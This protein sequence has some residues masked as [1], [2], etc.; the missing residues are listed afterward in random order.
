MKKAFKTYLEDTPIIAAVKNDAELAEAIKT[1]IQVI[2]I[3][4]GDICTIEDIVG[5]I[6]I[7]GRIAMVHL[8]LISGLSPKEATLKYLKEKIGVDGIITTKGNLTR[9]AKEIGLYIVV[10]FFVVDSMALNSIEKQC[11]DNWPDAIEV[12]PG[13]MPKIIKKIDKMSRVPIISG[14]LIADKD[15]VMAALN[16]GAIAISATSRKVWEM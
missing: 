2:F 6:K 3:L 7:A 8:D 10:R 12:L 11:R 15:D 9:C 14:G 16:A 5:R 1:D 4:Y 13:V